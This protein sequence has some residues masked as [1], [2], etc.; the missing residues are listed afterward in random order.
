M[1]KVYVVVVC[2]SCGGCVM[3]LVDYAMVVVMCDSYGCV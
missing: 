2:N 1:Y 3:V